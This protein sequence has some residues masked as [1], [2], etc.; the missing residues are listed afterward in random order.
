MTA[1]PRPNHHTQSENASF[2]GRED[3]EEEEKYSVEEGEITREDV[4]DVLSG[5]QT[6][7]YRCFTENN[8]STRD[9]CAKATCPNSQCRLN[10]RAARCNWRI[11]NAN[12]RPS[13]CRACKC[14]RR[15]TP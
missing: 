13:G 4:L 1:R 5:R 11:S 14:V 10:T 8:T 2:D 9:Q 12:K 6:P 3:F 15:T 7:R